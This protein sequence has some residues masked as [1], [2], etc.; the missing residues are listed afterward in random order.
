MH[1]HVVKSK[2]HDAYPSGVSIHFDPC[3]MV[4]GTP[5]KALLEVIDCLKND[6]AQVAKKS[7]LSIVIEPNPGETYIGAESWAEPDD[8]ETND[9]SS[10]RTVVKPSME[11][12]RYT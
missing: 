1:A 7:S 6:H 9:K 3:F 12:A 2:H 5:N 11:L 10:D 4:D 8:N